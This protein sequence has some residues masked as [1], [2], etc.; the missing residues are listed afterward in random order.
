M[1]AFNY[2][3]QRHMVYLKW[4]RYG[5]GPKRKYS[6]LEGAGHETRSQCWHYLGY[7]TVT[8]V[9][10]VYQWPSNVFIQVTCAAPGNVRSG[11][12]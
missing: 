3:K 7:L 4:I 2:L 8:K 6:V 9:A 12:V 10:V 1:A 5:S 11:T